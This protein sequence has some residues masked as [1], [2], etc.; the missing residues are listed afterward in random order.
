MFLHLKFHQN[1]NLFARF[2][3]HP[4]PCS[5]L[6]GSEIAF[7]AVNQN[8]GTSVAMEKG[9]DELIEHL[10]GEIAVCGPSGKSL[11]FCTASVLFPA[12][13][14]AFNLVGV[15]I[16]VDASHLF[17]SHKG[18]LATTI[19]NLSNRRGPWYC[20]HNRS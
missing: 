20:C 3:P 6:F 2:E 17:E 18:Q 1:Q 19:E 12:V 8:N 10:L 15:T 9:L 5:A 14:V 4:S 13:S 7:A 16:Q 11:L